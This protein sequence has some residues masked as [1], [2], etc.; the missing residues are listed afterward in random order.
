M[1]YVFLVP[2]KIDSLSKKCHF[3]SIF[4]SFPVK[5]PPKQ[6]FRVNFYSTKRFVFE[7]QGG[8][9]SY[10]WAI[11]LISA[12]MS[13]LED[14]GSLL[15]ARTVT[16]KNLITWYIKIR[17]KFRVWKWSILKK[18]SSDSSLQFKINLLQLVFKWIPTRWRSQA[19]SLSQSYELTNQSD[20]WKR[21]L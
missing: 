9:W 13:I 14:F 21:A 10:F 15:P 3:R 17:S 8:L 20:W 12:V 4:G 19:E 2:K 18:I 7:F 5:F 11:M 16:V 6:F 1:S